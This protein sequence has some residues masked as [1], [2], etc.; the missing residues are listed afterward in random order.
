VCFD[1]I[2]ENRHPIGGV[3]TRGCFDCIHKY[4]QLHTGICIFSKIYWCRPII[5]YA[6]KSHF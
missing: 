2:P 6:R 5:V 4:S 3:L 1:Q